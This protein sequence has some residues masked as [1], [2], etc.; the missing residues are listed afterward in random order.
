[1]GSLVVMGE[2]LAD[3]SVALKSST[4]ISSSYLDEV[5]LVFRQLGDT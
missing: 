3:T 2:W 4:S 5:G 1:M